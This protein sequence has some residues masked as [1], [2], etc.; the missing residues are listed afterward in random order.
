MA[1]RSLR[2]GSGDG[3][4]RPIFGGFLLAVKRWVC[5]SGAGRFQGRFIPNEKGAEQA[6]RPVRPRG[7]TLR[8]RAPGRGF[9]PP[10]FEPRTIGRYPLPIVCVE[11][12]RPHRADERRTGITAVG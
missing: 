5:V 4:W 10:A 12:L 8:P 11:A 6:G 3:V 2:G 1:W 9:A 7:R